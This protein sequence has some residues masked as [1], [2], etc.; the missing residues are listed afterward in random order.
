MRPFPLGD[1][2]DGMNVLR[3]K[4]GA[5]PNALQL[6]KNGWLTS[7][8]TAQARPGADRE[9]DFPAG[10]IG[11]LGHN[12]FFHTFSAVPTAAAAD[13]RVVVNVLRHPT[14]GPS[15]LST[16]H[17]AFPFLNRIY[18]VASFDDGVRKHYWLDDPGAWTALEQLDVGDRAQPTTKNGYY[19]AVK[20]TDTTPE[21][22]ANDEVAIGDF[23][24][25]S[26]PNGFKY[27]LTA[28]TGATL[29]TGATE[30]VWPTTAG[31]TVKEYRSG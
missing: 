23:V 13:P 31:A 22:A 26:T 25:P 1:Q 2:V 24:K 4:G 18:V 5:S 12:G 30:P 15:A 11:V 19:Y 8:R 17:T 14:A 3:T 16:I 10:T 21:W 7:K 20:D 28:G 27:Q 6:L 29:R 9:L